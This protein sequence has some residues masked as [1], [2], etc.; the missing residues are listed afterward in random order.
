MNKIRYFNLIAALALVVAALPL[1]QTARA[2]GSSP[3]LARG[4]QFV[5]GEAVVSFQNGQDAAAYTA[6]AA[7]LA[8]TVGAQVVKQENNLA[9]MSFAPDAD[10]AA[11]VGELA[12][13]DGVAFAEPN[14]VAFSP[15]AISATAIPVTTVEYATTG[16]ETLTLTA[17][18]LRDMRTRRK[19][20]GRMQAVPTYPN[21]F[22]NNWSWVKI[23]TDIIWPDKSSN[24]VVC[25]AD[26]GVDAS[27]PDLK[28]YVINGQDFVDGDFVPSDDNGHGTHVAGMIAARMNNGAATVAGISTSKILA[29]KV[30][31]SQGLGTSFDIASGI[32][33]CAS[34]GAKI[35]NLSLGG[36]S[37][38][39]AEYDALNYAES[40]KGLLVVTAAG[41]DSTSD[42]FFPAAWASSNVCQDGTAGPCAGGNANSLASGLISV[43]AARSLQTKNND[44]SIWVDANG[45]SVDDTIS[46]DVADCAT[47][48]SNFGDW[49]SMVAPGEDI[50][51]TTP[52]SNPFYM[53][54][55]EG[56]PFGYAA[57]S[58][59]SMAA[60]HVAGAAARVWSVGVALFGT[61]TRI[62]VKNQLINMGAPLNILDDPNANGG[63]GDGGFAG[64][65]PFCWPSSMSGATYL[66][67]A[68]AMQRMSIGA[69]LVLDANTGLPL[70]SAKVT[71]NMQG[72]SAIYDT[73]LVSATT[74]F[75]DLLN[76]PASATRTFEIKVSKTLY[77]T[78]AVKIGTM[79]VDP[80]MAGSV[81]SG[82]NLSTAIPKNVG[83]NVVA[84]WF[85]KQA[86]VPVYGAGAKRDLDLYMWTPPNGLPL[87]PSTITKFIVGPKETL[88]NSP[89]VDSYTY[90]GSLLSPPYARSFFDGGT[91]DL[92]PSVK[93]PVGLETIN[94]KQSK[95]V[96]KLPP[97]LSPYY[98]GQ[99]DFILTDNG[100]GK[101]TNNGSYP[102]TVTVWIKGVRYTSVTIPDGCAG[103]AWKALTINGTSYTL[104][105]NPVTSCGDF[106]EQPTGLWPYH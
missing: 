48:F 18:M 2:E 75:V 80:S 17:D 45:N 23:S 51:S 55:Y 74:P 104:G 68:D 31:N 41:N 76:I 60:A 61:P 1:A 42:F 49:V 19:V 22:S 85:N 57:L 90:F 71:V 29:V 34:K 11:V 59:T 86:Y 24:P 95:L 98:S 64:D 101:L 40:T 97:W 106:T 3:D 102:A 28:G 33:Y 35:I 62:N 30:L 93:T 67:V 25:V 58:G 69:I 82:D 52:N 70:S 12:A 13:H 94:I 54:Y 26:T 99:Y 9:L 96:S 16:G 89:G 66:N 36:Y 103:D 79:V 38:S 50:L 81:W 10:V 56:V 21:D 27:H 78:G 92:D 63:Y 15:D 7:A 32:R 100:S 53:N 47:N 88:W 87:T 72:S 14:F 73:A 65:G 8:E 46:E 84:S 83:I 91:G 6:Q 4:M 44:S 39:Q 105:T 5:P 43:A 77:T 37:A 20:G